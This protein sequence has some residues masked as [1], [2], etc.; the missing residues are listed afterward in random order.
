MEGINGSRSW[1][2]RSE[3]RQGHKYDFY[4]PRMKQCPSHVVETTSGTRVNEE[5]KASLLEGDVHKAGE[6][7]DYL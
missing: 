5:N 1:V 4:G 3:A 6:G 7:L 2:D